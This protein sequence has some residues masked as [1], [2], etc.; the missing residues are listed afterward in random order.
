MSSQEAS[1]LQAVN[2]ANIAAYIFNAA[3]T[4]GVG[5]SG[6]FPTNEELSA[7]YQTLVTP[8]GY[9]F[10][11]WGI[12]FLSEAVFTVLQALPA[13]RSSDV[14]V[15]GVGYYFVLACIAQ[16]SLVFSS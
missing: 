13:Y 1:K 8:S 2:Y 3:I 9:A 4:Y 10:A 6:Y 7:K 14:V 16:V 5:V 11:I 12:I 15:K